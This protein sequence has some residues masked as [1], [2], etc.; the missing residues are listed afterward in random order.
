[1]A[2]ANAA[3][4]TTAV[5]YIVCRVLVGLFPDWS[6]IVAQ[7][8]F[9]GI[10]LTKLSTWNLTMGNFILGL[11]TATIGAWLVSYLF[12]KIYNYFLKK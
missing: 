5:V 4:T 12:V 10:E 6:F 11:V 1:M 2:A 9:H 7:S 3:S 8:W